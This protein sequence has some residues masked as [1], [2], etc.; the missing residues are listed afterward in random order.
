MN[1]ILKIS[2]PSLRILIFKFYEKQN[3]LTFYTPNHTHNLLCSGLQ[4]RRH[5][6]VCWIWIGSF[7]AIKNWK[8]L[9]PNV[10]P[11]DS[12]SGTMIFSIP[13]SIEYS[14]HRKWGIGLM[15][16]PIFSIN[17]NLFNQLTSNITTTRNSSGMNYGIFGAYHFLNKSRFE[18]YTRLG[19]GLSKANYSESYS[20]NSSQ[21]FTYTMT[22]GFAKLAFGIR[23]YLN[24]HIC[25]FD[26]VGFMLYSLSSSSVSYQGQPVYMKENLTETLIGLDANLG[27]GYKF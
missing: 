21:K 13:I 23:I 27:I 14:L 24:K 22:G 18:A 11:S 8:T 7:A 4:K 16:A 6:P 26:E 1:N 19:F 10:H 2:L 17:S 5:Y 15:C 9:N 3:P 25:L 12:N 20:V